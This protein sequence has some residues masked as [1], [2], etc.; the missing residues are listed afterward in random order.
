M[1]KDKVRGG[2]G[3]GGVDFG[4]KKEN[5]KWIGRKMR[6]RGL[7]ANKEWR[8]FYILKDIGWGKR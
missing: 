7:E 1:I 8:M 5:Y 4:R 3:R 2:A 6:W